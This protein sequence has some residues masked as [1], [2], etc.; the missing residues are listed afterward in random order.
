[1]IGKQ[2]RSQT[3]EEQEELLEKLGK[4]SKKEGAKEE[5][6][7]S[8]E[9]K[10]EET[11]NQTLTKAAGVDFGFSIEDQQQL[12]DGDVRGEVIGEVIFDEGSETDGWAPLRVGAPTVRAPATA[13]G[14]KREPGVSSFEPPPP[15]LPLESD[16]GLE[17]RALS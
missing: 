1:M 12:P 9:E 13:A 16:V 11:K 17:F 6:K 7:G 15:N 3:K 4:Y 2:G 10:K 14:V 5:S 8:E